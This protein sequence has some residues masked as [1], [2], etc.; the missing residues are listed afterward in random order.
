MSVV[1]SGVGKWILSGANTYTGATTIQGGTLQVSKTVGGITATAS[2]T[3]TSLTVDFGGVTP[4]TGSAYKFFPASTSPTN[5]T[6]TLTNAGGKT[7]TY[8]YTNSTLTIN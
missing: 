6:V 4:T 2:F 8:N 5:L 1:K 7:G 3:T